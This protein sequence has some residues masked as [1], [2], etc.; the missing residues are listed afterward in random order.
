MNKHFTPVKPQKISIVY[1]LIVAV[2]AYLSS[3]LSPYVG[4]LLALFTMIVI[5]FAS[6]S[7]WPTVKKP[8]KPL[9]FSL[10]W[11]LIIGLLIPYLITKNM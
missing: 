11:G 1:T 8:E 6:D 4:Y 2:I 3:Q 10:F 5:G 9:V 7:I